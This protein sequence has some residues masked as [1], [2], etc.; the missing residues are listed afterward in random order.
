M[1]NTSLI[2]ADD[3]MLIAI[4]IQDAFLEKLTT[5]Q[6]EELI[7]RACWLIN[8]AK[9]LNIPIVVTA[10]DIADLGTVHSSI[11]NCLNN[12]SIY[13]KLIFGLTE[14]ADIMKAIQK[15]KRKTCIL[16]GLETDVCVAQSALELMQRGYQVIVVADAT[17]SPKKAHKAGLKRIQNAGGLIIYTK[18]LYYEWIRTVEK[19]KAF[20]LEFPELE[21]ADNF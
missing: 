11:Q 5:L 19:A 20:K 21:H 6:A 8:V 15:T 1:P 3:C 18:A 17:G 10:E 4:D 16:I 14:Q 7:S 13:D 2:E 9:W 12:E